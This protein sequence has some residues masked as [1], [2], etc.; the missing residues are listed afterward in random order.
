MDK[1]DWFAL[2]QET[3]ADYVALT[4]GILDEGAIA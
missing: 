3:R 4:E 2:E 1:L